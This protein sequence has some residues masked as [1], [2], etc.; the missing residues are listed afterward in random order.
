MARLRY[1]NAAGTLGS[2][3]LTNT[4]TTITFASAPPFATLVSPNY[5]PLALDPPQGP[6][7]SPSFEI[8]WLTAYT[9]GATKGTILRGQEGTTAIA[10]NV[11]AVWAQAVTLVDIQTSPVG[12]IIPYAGTGD[13]PESNWVIAD[14][15]LIGPRTTT[16]ADFFARVG[17]AYN[18]GVDPGSGNVRIPDKR[19]RHSIGAINMGSAAGAGAND[20]AHA[21]LAVGAKAGEV[22]HTLA[23]TEGPVHNHW[24]ALSQT[25]LNHKHYV[26]A[27]ASSSSSSSSSSS[28]GGHTHGLGPGQGITG[29]WASNPQSGT[30]GGGTAI[31]V[32]WYLQ[33]S[34]VGYASISTS[35][36]TST[37]TSV[38]IGDGYSGNPYDYDVSGT[39]GLGGHW[40]HGHTIPWDLGTTPSG[41]ASAG[42]TQAHNNLPPYECDS[43]IVRIA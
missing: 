11:G 8:V 27:S 18:G 24:N 16:Y 25:D 20:N 1:N 9:A 2:P 35:T 6:S 26:P 38:T 29:V 15:R 4:A 34:D 30:I 39:Y 40:Y 36:S 37:S 41:G 31:G 28:D 42:S 23:T 32:H 17:H 5:I 10:H 21:Q 3:A 22:N 7:P 12:S 19:G 33:G 14:G 43:Y 13:P